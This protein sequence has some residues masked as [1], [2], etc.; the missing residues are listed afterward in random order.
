[1]ALSH[2]A[3]FSKDWFVANLFEKLKCLSHS[4]LKVGTGVHDVLPSGQGCPY[5][6]PIF[7]EGHIVAIEGHHKQHS[8]D[9]IETLYPLTS[10]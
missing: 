8:L 4:V 1:M 9:I 5:R 6:D 10:L 3:G 7:S 2:H